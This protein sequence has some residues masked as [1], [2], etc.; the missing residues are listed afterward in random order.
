[1]PVVS[2]SKRSRN[3]AAE[4]STRK[5]RKTTGEVATESPSST[6]HFV[7]GESRDRGGSAAFLNETEAEQSQE[8]RPRR[9]RRRSSAE[10]RGQ[11]LSELP[12]LS[13]GEGSYDI[14]QDFDL[15]RS[16]S[17]CMSVGSFVSTAHALFDRFTTPS[18]Q[19][20]S[21]P[22]SGRFGDADFDSDAPS[23]SRSETQLRTSVGEGERVVEDDAPQTGRRVQGMSTGPFALW[24]DSACYFALLFLLVFLC[25]SFF[26]IGV[27]LVLHAHLGAVNSEM[28]E[29]LMASGSI[30]RR[31]S[32]FRAFNWAYRLSFLYLVWRFFDKLTGIEM[33]KY[34]TFNTSEI[35]AGAFEIVWTIAICDVLGCFPFSNLAKANLR[36]DAD[37]TP[38]SVL[39]RDMFQGRF[40]APRR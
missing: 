38:T 12:A 35:D 17:H 3:A 18:S 30:S 1:M 6:P 32:V 34:L 16:N 14:P 20:R 27:I 26:W 40:A 8:L 7:G 22:S 11:R 2:K 39:F 37:S 13:M 10:P 23:R 24:I 25:S 15:G 4:S 29:D 36:P 33:Q 9:R 31:S 21:Q 19:P 5:K 28:K